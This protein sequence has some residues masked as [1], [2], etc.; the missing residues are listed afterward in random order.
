MADYVI[1]F[2]AHSTVYLAGNDILLPKIEGSAWTPTSAQNPANTDEF[3]ISTQRHQVH[4]KGKWGVL[5]ILC[6]S[7]SIKFYRSD[8]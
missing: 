8:E 7:F 3:S 2:P 4:Q 5:E 6:H 1:E